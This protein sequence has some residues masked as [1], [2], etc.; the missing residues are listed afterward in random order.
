MELKRIVANDSNTALKNVK[1]ECGD[2]ALIVSTNRIGQKTEVIYAVDG[3]TDKTGSESHTPSNSQIT[4]AN[5]RFSDSIDEE[6]LGRKEVPPKSD[7][8]LILS[9]IQK[10]IHTL[11]TKLD[12]SQIKLKSKETSNSVLKISAQ[13]IRRRLEIMSQRSIEEQGP[14]SG[15]NILVSLKHQPNSEFFK[16]IIEGIKKSEAGKAR[17]PVLSVVCEPNEA[18]NLFNRRLLDFVDMAHSSN[19]QFLMTPCL[20]ELSHFLQHNNPESSILLGLFCP[21]QTSYDQASELL[22]KF[23]GRISFAIDCDQTV[24]SIAK[25]LSRIPKQFRSL[26]LY[27]NRQ[28]LVS[29]DLIHQLAASEFDIS[30]VV[31]S[32]EE[33]IGQ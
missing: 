8:S 25:D 29:E 24:E 17:V 16:S 3:N 30:G 13:S 4:P 22:G 9:E 26:I 15:L 19:V 11:R 1:D 20:K 32:I 18:K 28:N 21:S 12:G 14:W 6:L 33:R 23:A 5:S 31:S 2:D 10:E 27:S 7:M